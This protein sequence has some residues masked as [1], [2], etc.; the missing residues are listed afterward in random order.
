MNPFLRWLCPARSLALALLSLLFS[1]SGAA[2]TVF[3]PE[4]LNQMESAILKQIAATNLP[5][6]V[7]W[8]EHRGETFHK[9]FGR[10]SVWPVTEGMTEDTLFDAA[11]LTKVLATT[12]SV[13]CLVESG[14]VSLEDPI[15]RY[16]PEFTAAR[17]NRITLRLMLTHTSGLPPGI[18]L[19]SHWT[20]YEAGIERACGVKLATAPGTKFTYSDVNFILLGELVR[21]VS[22][23]P[24]DEYARR[25]IYQPLGMVDT[26]FRPLRN[27]GDGWHRLK[28]WV[29]RSFAE[30]FMTR[31]HGPWV[32]WQAMPACLPR[33]RTWRVF[34]G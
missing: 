27:F 34:V 18:E 4:V 20:G 13:M 24:L 9:A 10:R 11:S 17:S 2:A 16:F 31:L 7:L 15:E 5:G 28:R 22:G 30:W 6:G 26:G 21:R 8:L 29:T 3:R 19:A 1:G 14:Q 32:A 25:K 33:L 23:Y 12:P